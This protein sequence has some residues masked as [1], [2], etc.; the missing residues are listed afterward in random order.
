M[1][2]KKKPRIIQNFN[3]YK[4]HL[5]S[6]Q[7]AILYSALVPSILAQVAVDVQFVYTANANVAR[8]NLI[9]NGT[10]IFRRGCYTV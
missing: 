9:T 3:P 5:D 7:E 10:G 8:Y 2:Y 4:V 6:E 1:N